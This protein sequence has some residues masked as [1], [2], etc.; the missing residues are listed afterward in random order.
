MRLLEKYCFKVD[1]RG[2]HE[3]ELW[4]SSFLTVSLKVI[5]SRPR[6]FIEEGRE[7]KQNNAMM[8]VRL[9]RFLFFKLKYVNACF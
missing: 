8:T 5:H 1:L 4:V 2:Q 3:V 9:C 7:R 6:V